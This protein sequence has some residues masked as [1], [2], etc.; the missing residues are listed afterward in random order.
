MVKSEPLN[1]ESI[2]LRR[3]PRCGL[4]TAF[5]AFRTHSST[6]DLLRTSYPQV[7]FASKHYFFDDRRW[8][9]APCQLFLAESFNLLGNLHILTIHAYYNKHIVYRQ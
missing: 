7:S 3:Y 5:R 1:R 6:G 4:H 9:F 8:L 2:R